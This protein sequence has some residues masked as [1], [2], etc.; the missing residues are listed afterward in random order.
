METKWNFLFLVFLAANFSCQ[1][2]KQIDDHYLLGKCF[3]STPLV[4]Q[5]GEPGHYWPALAEAMIEKGNDFQIFTTSDR[6]KKPTSERIKLS[7]GCTFKLN[8]MFR[9]E[10][11]SLTAAYYELL[12]VSPECEISHF[13]G[14][15]L[16]RCINEKS[17]EPDCFVNN[18]LTMVPCP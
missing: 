3:F 11:S 18:N 4:L 8:R 1:H 14:S 16:F 13:Y 17:T 2:V 10:S 7:N 6:E 12:S 5:R 15:D 9:T